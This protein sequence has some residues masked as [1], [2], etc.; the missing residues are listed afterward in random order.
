LPGWQCLEIVVV[1]YSLQLSEPLA[2][3]NI[4]EPPLESQRSFIPA[5]H[6]IYLFDVF[7]GCSSEPKTYEDCIF[8]NMHKAQSENYAR[9]IAYACREN[10]SEPTNPLT[11]LTTHKLS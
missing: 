10:F 9:A 1:R 4:H 7:F 6:S 3:G 11:D 8:Q 2:R 5:F